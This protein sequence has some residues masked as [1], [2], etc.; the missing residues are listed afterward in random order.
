MRIYYAVM[1]YESFKL[2]ANFK[3]RCL[4]EGARYS[5]LMSEIELPL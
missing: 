5:S 1:L 4:P 3:S 2:N